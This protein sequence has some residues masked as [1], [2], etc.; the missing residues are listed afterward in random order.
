MAVDSDGASG[1][2]A[3]DDA[4]RSA[5]VELCLRLADDEFVLAERYTEWQVIA[6]TLESDLAL[7]NIAQDEL[8]HAR[9]F[10]DV[11]ERLGYT[12]PGLIFEREPADFRHGTLVELPFAEGDWAD[13]IVRSYCYDEAERRRLEPLGDAAFEPLADPIGKVLREEEFHRDH[14]RRW[15]ERLCGDPEG[16]DR[17]QAAVDRLLPHALTLFVPGDHEATIEAMGLRDGSLA[18]MRDDWLADVRAT[19]DGLGVDVPD[20]DET[21]VDALLPDVRGRDGTHTD[22][23]P[24][25]HE[26]LTH[27]YRELD[28]SDVRRLRGGENG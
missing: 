18:A 13:V 7:A 14:A 16:R 12:E 1:V 28:R 19:L 2:G 23:W 17:V 11:L 21:R 6:P 5:V 24:S 20:G 26:E 8:G 9:I 25:L 22:A 27:T 3:L 10:Y 15:L 4:E